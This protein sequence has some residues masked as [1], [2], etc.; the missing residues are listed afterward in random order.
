MAN[1]R[2]IHAPTFQIWVNFE[3][4]PDWILNHV[5]SVSYEDNS[6]M[7]D[8]ISISIGTQVVTE[9]D[10][11]HQLIDSRYFTEGN[12]IEIFMGYGSSLNM[13]GAGEIVLIKPSFPMDGI[14]SLTITCY[15][16]IHRLTVSKVDNKGGLSYKKQRDSDIVKTIAQRNGLNIGNI[17]YTA[18]IPKTI[19]QEK[20]KSDYA[21]L[22]FLAERNSYEL[23]VRF[24][25]RWNIYFEPYQDR[26]QKKY[27]F[28]YNMTESAEDNTL[29]EFNPNMN[30]SDQATEYE[31]IG[32]DREKAK[33]LKAIVRGD[34]LFKYDTTTEDIADFFGSTEPRKF[35]GSE[36]LD[37]LTEEVKEPSLIKF[38]AFGLHREIIQ[39][40]SIQDEDDVEKK[41]KNWVEERK[42]HFVTGTGSVIGIEFLQTRQV[43]ELLGLGV[44]LSGMYYF[45]K[46]THQ[47]SS[48]SEYK[49]SFSCRK[50]V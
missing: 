47:M 11:I 45:T 44:S 26:K 40:S 27:T 10:Q 32:F 30:I 21:F 23:Y 48:D 24:E 6:E 18:G 16:I 39:D 1:P 46:V 50:V 8:K 34:K 49:C 13:V 25:N 43:H 14:P 4:L 42:K 28:K 36:K 33:K 37:P 9:K 17:V 12:F 38:K 3:I 22:R 2:D 41:I 35:A 15:D 29:L 31:F 5:N 20:G 7:M 19:V